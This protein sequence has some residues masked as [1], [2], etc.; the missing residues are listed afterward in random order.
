[1]PTRKLSPPAVSWPINVP[2]PTPWSSSRNRPG[3]L[4]RKPK[5]PQSLRK[6]EKAGGLG[7]IFTSN[8]LS[9]NLLP[10]AQLPQSSNPTSNLPNFP[11]PPPKKKKKNFP[12]ANSTRKQP[13]FAQFPEAHI[14]SPP[15]KEKKKKHKSPQKPHKS[16]QKPTKKKKQSILWSQ[17]SWS[18]CSFDPHR[19]WASEGPPAASPAA[20]RRHGPGTRFCSFF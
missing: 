9:E 8:F 17:A 12:K 2:L 16:P 4:Q 5:H 19:S 15:P 7:F 3:V 14:C 11:N 6:F 18:V 10:K 13:D 1:M 20:C